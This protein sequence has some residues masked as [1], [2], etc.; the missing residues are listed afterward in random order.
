M[1][2]EHSIHFVF[3]DKTSSPRTEA[4]KLHAKK[5]KIDEK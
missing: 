3:M 4:T 2:K 5:V 1:H